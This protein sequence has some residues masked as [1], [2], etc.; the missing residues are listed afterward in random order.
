MRILTPEIVSVLL[1]VS[2]FWIIRSIMFGPLEGKSL[3]TRWQE[4][5]LACLITLLIGTPVTFLVV[6]LLF[7]LSYLTINIRSSY[8]SYYQYHIEKHII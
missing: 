1:Q 3:S 6:F 2:L 4:G 8:L 5:M 7:Y